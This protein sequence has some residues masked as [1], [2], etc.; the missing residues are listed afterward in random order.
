MIRINLLP[1][2]KKN[3][4]IAAAPSGSSNTWAGIYLVAVAVWCV[5]LGIA[6]YRAEG[7][8][9][10]QNRQN[11]ALS[12]QIEGL[13]QRSA[14]LEE[15]EAA[16]AQSRHLEEVVANLHK[17]RTGPIRVM[18]ELG[19]MLSQGGGPTIDPEALERLRR[20]NPLAGYNASWDVRRLWLTEFKENRRECRIA[21]RGRTNEDVA[22]LLRR[23]SLSELFERVTLTKTEAIEDRDVR[24]SFTGFEL[25]CRVR[26]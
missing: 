12:Q 5:G 9:E 17:S 10:E 4:R 3:V 21:G 2:S 25:T 24:L 15:V 14:R 26:Y 22:E 13:R 18:M 7:V 8:L 11:A 1:A 6:Y 19:R 16:L 20:E 23:L